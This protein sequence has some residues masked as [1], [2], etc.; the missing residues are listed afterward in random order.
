[1]GTDVRL[2]NPDVGR[3]E[4]R[5][6]AFQD[7]II[8]HSWFFYKWDGRKTCLLLCCYVKPILR[9]VLYSS[10]TAYRLNHSLETFSN[11]LHWNSVKLFVWDHSSLCVQLGNFSC[12]WKFEMCI[13]CLI[14]N[15]LIRTFQIWLY[16]IWLNK[17][18]CISR[19]TWI[20]EIFN[21][22]SELNT[23]RV[24]SSLL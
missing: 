13:L 7:K 1:M 11:I 23:N 22:I 14:I 21:R 8:T 17:L 10:T 24:G 12:A 2:C 9:V 3:P 19:W 4:H 15:F 5:V 16:I 18:R 6:S 20:G